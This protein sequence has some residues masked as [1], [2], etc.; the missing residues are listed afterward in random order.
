MPDPDKTYQP[1]DGE[2]SEYELA[3][4]TNAR[5]KRLIRLELRGPSGGTTEQRV[6]QAEAL[7]FDPERVV[8]MEENDIDVL[9]LFDY[10][11]RASEVV[12]DIDT[13]GRAEDLRMDVAQEAI[14]DFIE[15][16]NI[17]SGA[18]RS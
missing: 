17:T 7:G 9:N 16:V 2:A 15:S 13:S 11:A 12:L 4:P 5:V 6:R 18:T 10:L 8:P 3:C 1:F 14:A